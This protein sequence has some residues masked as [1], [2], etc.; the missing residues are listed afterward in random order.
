MLLTAAQSECRH[1]APTTLYFKQCT[2]CDGVVASDRPRECRSLRMPASGIAFGWTHYVCLR[3]PMHTDRQGR[4]F[5]PFSAPKANSSSRFALLQGARRSRSHGV[6]GGILVCVLGQYWP[7]EHAKRVRHTP[8][9]D[10]GSS[11]FG[12]SGL[13]MRAQRRKVLRPDRA[14]GVK[15]RSPSARS[16]CFAHPRR[17]SHRGIRA[18]AQRAYLEI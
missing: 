8:T 11:P 1:P 18:V 12:A 16:P 13:V 5:R 15:A 7:S 4:S 3:L 2:A 9:L 17:V 10:S 14:S 6:L